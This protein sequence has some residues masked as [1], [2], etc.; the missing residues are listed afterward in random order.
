MP[1]AEKIFQPDLEKIRRLEADPFF[2]NRQN[3]F[4]KKIAEADRSDFDVWWFAYGLLL[5]YG[6]E[7]KK[8]TP[9][10]QAK[11]LPAWLIMLINGL[12][13]LIDWQAKRIKVK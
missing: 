2:S 10:M 11:G 8:I 1:V 7:L 4:A 12:A 13:T 3:E 9:L 5:R 6:S